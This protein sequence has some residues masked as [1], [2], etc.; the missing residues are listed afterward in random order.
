MSG[1]S[2]LGSPE[3]LHGAPSLVS[4]FFWMEFHSPLSSPHSPP[5]PGPWLTLVLPAVPRASEA[6]PSLLPCPAHFKSSSGN[7]LQSCAHLLFLS[8]ALDLNFAPPHLPTKVLCLLYKLNT[9][10]GVTV[11]QSSHFKTQLTNRYTNRKQ[12]CGGTEWVAEEK[13]C[14]LEGQ[15]QDWQGCGNLARFHTGADPPGIGVQL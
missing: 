10:F 5:G 8:R 14:W 3:D 1:L 2:P 15:R 13:P 12:V 9:L 11:C 7:S 6:L 4:V